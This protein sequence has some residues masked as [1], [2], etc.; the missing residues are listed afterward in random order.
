MEGNFY[1]SQKSVSIRA[2]GQLARAYAQCQ[3]Q[4]D[5]YGHCVEIAHSN[6]A[7]EKDTCK[8]QRLALRECIDRAVDSRCAQSVANGAPSAEPRPTPAE[9][10]APR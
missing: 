3:P 8:E 7:L 2:K 10:T 5:A 9:A 6:K 4:A 1:T